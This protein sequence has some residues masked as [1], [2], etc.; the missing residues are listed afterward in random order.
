MAD[1]TLRV[2]AWDENA[3]HVSKEIYPGNIGAAVAEGLNEIGGGR[4]AA[5]RAHLDEPDQG[6]PDSLLAET[7]VLLWW[8]HAR[9]DL[10][11]PETAERIRRHVH[12]RGMGF[13]GLHS[14]HYS[15]PFGLV[16]GCTGDLKGG[17]REVH[18]GFEPEEIT[19][20]APRHPIAQGVKDFVLDAEEMYGAPFSVPPPAVVVFQSYFPHGGEYFPSG[21]VW[22]VG[23]GIDPN[24][25]SGGGN[26][27][28]QGEGKG[29]VFYF[30]PGHETVPTYH[31]PT[32]RRIL[33]NAVLWCGRKI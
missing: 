11:T 15:K 14:A 17:W 28:N 6:V 18:P 1:G 13:I 32:V 31:H 21:A 7:D 23:D 3:G 19:V 22:T 10:V 2:L 27:Q 4:I 16:L 20:A 12:H 8:G 25:T 5:R 9:H 33:A 30:R 24:F 29:R 26:G